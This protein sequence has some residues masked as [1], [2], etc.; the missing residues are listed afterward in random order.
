MTAIIKELYIAYKAARK[1]KRNTKSQLEFEL[2]LEKN[3]YKLAKQILELNYEV[4]PNKCFI[5]E[6]PVVREI[7]AA[8]FS[9]RVIHHFIFNRVND[10]LDKKFIHDSFSCRKGKGTLFGVNR[11]KYHINSATK[12]NT[13]KAW[14]LKLDLSG[15]F[16]SIPREKLLITTL[17]LANAKNPVTKHLITKTILHNPMEK[18]IVHQNKKLQ[19]LLPKKKSLFHTPKSC[20][21]PIGNLT[22]Q[23]FSNVYLNSMDHYIKRN[24]KCKYYGRYVDDFYIVHNSK[25]RL[26]V[27]LKEIKQFLINNLDLEIHPKKIYLQSTRKSVRFL[28]NVILNNQTKPIPRITNNARIK[29][30]DLSNLFTSLDFAKKKILL[31]EIVVIVNSYLGILQHS[32]KFY[33]RER[34]INMLSEEVRLN[35]RWEA[36]ITKVNII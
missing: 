15:Y 23:L 21:L 7:F 26:K 36:D 12:N 9:D 29:L 13:E 14:I 20:G 30:R 31:K 3:L 27:V 16:M 1:N 28:G 5:V 8:Q 34:V 17:K 32:D 10:V 6:H 19:G 18:C 35:L 33:L 25:K 2:N 24:L 22:S 4:K 11:L